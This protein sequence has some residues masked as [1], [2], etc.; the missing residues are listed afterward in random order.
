MFDADQLKRM[1]G[2]AIIHDGEE[3]L[4]FGSHDFDQSEIRELATHEKVKRILFHVCRF[5]DIDFT[6][7]SSLRL[8]LVVFLH[9]R[10][11]D[12][13]MEQLKSWKHL[14][15]LKLHDVK[16]TQGKVTELQEALPGL[17]ILC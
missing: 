8:D 4:A 12:A 5:P 17:E 11:S 14:K 9:T 7:L 1:G 3:Y 2:K 6:A 16:V 10:L 13:Q 15:S